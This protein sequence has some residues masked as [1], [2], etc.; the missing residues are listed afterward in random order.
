MRRSLRLLSFARRH[1]SLAWILALTF[2]IGTPFP[3][4]PWVSNLAAQTFT[5]N[6]TTLSANVAATDTSITVASSS[7]A[8]GSSFGPITAGQYLFVDQESMLIMSVSSTTLTVRRGI[9]PAPHASG[10]TVYVGPANSFMHAD[11]PPG[12]CTTASQQALWIN[13]DTGV[14]FTCGPNSLWARSTAPWYTP[15]NSGNGSTLTLSA[16]QS[17]MTFLFDR[18]AGIVYT[19]PKPVPGMTFDFVV[20]VT[21]TSNAATVVTDGASTFI[22]GNIIGNVSGAASNAAANLTG[23]VCNGTSH[24]KVTMNGTTTGGILGSRLHFVAVSSTVWQVDGLAIQT[25]A[26]ATPCST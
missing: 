12:R 17:G 10:S 7:A 1:R 26:I 3:P 16:G 4:A 18:A 6:S 11:P 21:I 5:H 25:V 19:L 8:S 9:R 2:L 20:T 24:I 22:Q 23:W 14:I 13:A 15:I